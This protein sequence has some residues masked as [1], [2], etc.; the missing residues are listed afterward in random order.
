MLVDYLSELSAMARARVKRGYYDHQ[1]SVKHPHRSLVEA[2]KKSDKTAVI[3]EIKYASPSAGK[4]RAS[5][6]PVEIAKAMLA[7]GCCA[8]SVLTE[9]DSFQG[10]LDTLTNVSQA[11]NVPVIMKDI[12]VSPIQLRA[13]ANAG[14]DAV[15]L[16]FEVFSRGLGEAGL[17]EMIA[18]ASR[19]GLEALVEVNGTNEFEKLPQYKPE[20][21]GINNRD[22]STFKLDL[23]TTEKIL[24]RV[25]NPDKPVVSESG[26]V[27]ARDIRR[28]RKAGAEAFLVGT[29]IMKSSDIEGKVRELVNA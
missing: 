4:I 2:I 6:E 27:S 20:L 12:L 7:G 9:P 17:N 5:E 13:G 14:A 10:R 21:Y 29:S 3:T 15:V 28:L 18:E 24:A 19:L 22:L 16:I 23:S 1:N 8:L 25:K 11:V 26:I